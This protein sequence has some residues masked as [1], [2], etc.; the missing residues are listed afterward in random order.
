MSCLLRLGAWQSPRPARF[1][2]EI[3]STSYPTATGGGSEGQSTSGTRIARHIP[4]AEAEL[5]AIF[6][7]VPEPIS[8]V[9]P[10][11]IVELTPTDRYSSLIFA[12]AAASPG[13]PKPLLTGS[14]DAPR[15]L[16][17]ELAYTRWTSRDEW[18]AWRDGGW[19]Q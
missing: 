6:A 2:G 13:A 19:V 11:Q 16:A 12:L 5:A 10:P 17:R 8:E 1:L 14:P 9:V 18:R 4:D 7:D 3:A 15:W